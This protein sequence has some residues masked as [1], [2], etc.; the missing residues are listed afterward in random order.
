[1]VPNKE[2]EKEKLT[3]SVVKANL[4][5]V[6]MIIPAA[7]I[8][9]YPY[10][11]IWNK[12]ES[13]IISGWILLLTLV[14]GIIGHELLH[15]ITWAWYAPK[16]IRSI[17]FGMMWKMLTPYC[18]CKEPLTVRSYI[19]GALM[20]GIVLGIVPG[21]L[22]IITGSA[23][24]LIFAVVFTIAA[25]GDIMTVNLLRH[26]H[27]DTLVQDHPSEAGCIVYRNRNG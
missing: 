14:T 8:F 20:P 13:N 6:L 19:I 22:A 1:M 3:I 18:H 2:F 9:G 16:G 23:E 10:Y 26:E 15:G 5:G 4:F 27:K 21:V 25:T 11:L 12:L 7:I 24:L 17:R